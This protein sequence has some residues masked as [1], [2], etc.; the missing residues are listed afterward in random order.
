MINAGDT[1]FVLFSSALVML[2]TL[3]LAFFYGGL[4]RAKNVLSI[5]MQCL[6][7]ACVLSLEWILF[8]YSLSFAPGSAFIG[9]LKFLGLRGVGA[10]PN[11]AY[12]STIPHLAFMLF[13]GMFAVITPALIIGAFAERI[14]FSAFLIFSILWAV[15]VYNPVAHWIWGEGGWLAKLGFIDFAG[16]V[17]VHLTAGIAAIVMCILIGKRKGFPETPMIPHNVPMV[18]LGLTLLWFG[19]FGFNGGSALAANSVAAYAFVATNTAAATAG[20]T[21]AFI[22]WLTLGAPTTVGTATGAVAGLA[23]VTPASGFISP[24]SAIFIGIISACVCFFFVAVVKQKL[25]YDDSL[26][27]FGV[28]GIGGIIGTLC[29]GLFAQTAVNPSGP[30]GLFFGNPHQFLIQLVGVSVAF[31]YTLTLTFVIGKLVDIWVGLRVSDEDEEMGLD[32][33]QHKE[34]AYTT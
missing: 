1:A 20:I 5:I 33:S 7:L 9:G 34:S 24:I 3:G 14:K 15:L 13:Q 18:Y 11:T 29:A 30:N 26:D 16:G 25:S 8:G 19:W 17:V 31:V 22:E 2:M 4:V 23:A 27:V 6:A 21:W 28:H 12:S 10:T 32:V